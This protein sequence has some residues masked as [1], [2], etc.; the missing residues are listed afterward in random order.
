VTDDDEEGFH[1][2]NRCIYD[3]KPSDWRLFLGSQFTMRNIPLSLAPYHVPSLDGIAALTP[4]FTDLSA[5]GVTFL[6][7]EGYYSSIGAEVIRS[8][9]SRMY[10]GFKLNAR[11][12]DTNC[13]EV[14]LL[15]GQFSVSNDEDVELDGGAEDS[16]EL[17]GNHVESPLTAS[18]FSQLLVQNPLQSFSEIWRE[19]RAGITSV[20]TP[21]ETTGENSDSAYPYP[22]ITVE[23]FAQIW[24]T[25]K[26]QNESSTSNP[27]VTE[28]SS[29]DDS[30]DFESYIRGIRI[31]IPDN[32]LL[33]SYA[34]T[35]PVPYCEVSSSSNQDFIEY[36]QEI[37]TPARKKRNIQST[38]STAPFTD[39]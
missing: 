37:V 14:N 8:L 12:L 1:E 39:R 9:D 13:T 26:F 15:E 11:N 36:T 16:P 23:R 22:Q 19:R 21:Q 4:I 24:R 6:S 29:D 33:P 35:P 30:S 32:S 17:A 38:P 34:D 28:I 31:A 10:L 3:Q 20:I 2:R 5:R 25:R 18:Q 7:D 27:E